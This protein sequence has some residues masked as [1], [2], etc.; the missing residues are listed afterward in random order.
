LT[1]EITNKSQ[2]RSV[3][4]VGK[5]IVV[6]GPNYSQPFQPETTFLIQEVHSKTYRPKVSNS[7]TIPNKGD[8]NK[9]V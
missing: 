8:G 1:L 3:P 6:P 7:D 2:M 5:I 4:F 9:H